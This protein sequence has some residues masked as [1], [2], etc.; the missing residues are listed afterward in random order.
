[1]TRNGLIGAGILVVLV[2]DRVGPRDEQTGHRMVGE[3]VREGLYAAV[4][5]VN[6]RDL[7]GHS[8]QG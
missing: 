2:E 6:R 7:R 5:T 3:V 1:M 4:I 8:F